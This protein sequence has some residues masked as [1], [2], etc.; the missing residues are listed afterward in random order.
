MPWNDSNIRA[1]KSIE[2]ILDPKSRDTLE[3]FCRAR[4][5][6]RPFARLIQ[7]RRSGVYRQTVLSNLSLI[8]AVL[9]RKL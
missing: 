3:R 5:D 1:L 9:L 2:P 4:G 7:L 8:A 6:A